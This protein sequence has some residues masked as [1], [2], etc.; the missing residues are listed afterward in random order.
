MG[1]YDGYLTLIHQQAD[2]DRKINSL[3]IDRLRRNNAAIHN[4][5]RKKLGANYR[6]CLP[7][8]LQWTLHLNSLVRAELSEEQITLMWTENQRIKRVN[9]A[10][11]TSTNV[12][13]VEMQRTA[14]IST[15]WLHYSI[16]DA[17]RETRRLIREQKIAEA[18]EELERLTSKTSSLKS[19]AQTDRRQA[20]ET[21]QKLLTHEREIKA[22]REWLD[23]LVQANAAR[24]AP[25]QAKTDALAQ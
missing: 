19:K 7:E 9:F 10:G 3:I 22:S 13:E 17:C 16:W 11:A 4:V 15:D 6:K 21:D 25:T 20:S 1:A 5:A 14:V 23:Q 12:E 24:N 8:S 18:R 2:L